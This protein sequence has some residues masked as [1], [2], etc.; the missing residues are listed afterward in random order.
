VNS[1][2]ADN[3]AASSPD[4]AGSLLSRGFNLF[5]VHS[6]SFTP[7]GGDLL[8]IDP[9]LQAPLAGV[10]PTLAGSPARDA[11]SPDPTGS[12]GASCARIDGLGMKRPQDGD[13]SGTAR[14][15]IGAIESVGSTVLDIDGDGVVVALTDGLLALRWMFGMTGDALVAGV[16]MAGA[17]R[18]TAALVSQYLGSIEGALD[19]DGNGVNQA[20]AD[21]L[22]IVRYL[23][24]LSGNSLTNGA[25]GAGAT[26]TTADQVIAYL[27][28]LD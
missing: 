17:P 12:L 4:C 18:S 5:G 23:F 7:A 1:I 13:A 15:D 24:G 22:L 10:Y 19:V 9:E 26:R 27:A 14:C 3:L 16:V 25:I 11:G 2:L 8:G 6:C 20:L 28:L 21:G